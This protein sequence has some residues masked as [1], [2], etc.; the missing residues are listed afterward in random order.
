MEENHGSVLRGMFFGKGY[1][2]PPGIAPPSKFVKDAQASM[3]VSFRHGLQQLPDALVSHLTQNGVELQ[4]DWPVG[5]IELPGE[6]EPDSVHVQCASDPSKTETFDVVFSTLSAQALA[7][8]LSSSCAEADAGT[9]SV[10]KGATTCM[11]LEQTRKTLGTIRSSS[12]ASISLGYNAGVLP[13]D[14]FGYLIPS[15]E[16]LKALGVIFDS[17]VFPA[18]N[19]RPWHTRL[20]VMAGGVHHPEL[21]GM[22]RDELVELAQSTVKKHLKIKQ[23]ADIAIVNAHHD[24]IPQYDVGHSQRLKDILHS[25]QRHVEGKGGQVGPLAEPTVEGMSAVAASSKLFILG[26]SFWGVGVSDCVATSQEAAT[27][28]AAQL[29]PGGVIQEHREM[30][31]LRRQN[32]ELEAKLTAIG[33][34]LAAVEAK[35]K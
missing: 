8:T 10:S 4:T 24:C 33:A 27:L 6:G 11:H 20:T 32:S 16:K 21:I 29:Q 7:Q 31:E 15:F 34:R 12:V 17:H 18:Q 19:K 23:D 26:N 9:A 13:Y 30:A 35:L 28:F 14:G 5:N 1:E 25:L 22:P 3:S 2:N